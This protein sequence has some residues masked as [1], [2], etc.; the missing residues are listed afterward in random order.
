M[1][2][3][4]GHMLCHREGMIDQRGNVGGIQGGGVD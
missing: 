3:D 2:S 4:L 1:K